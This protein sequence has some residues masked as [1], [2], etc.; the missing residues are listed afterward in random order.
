MAEGKGV[1]ESGEMETK[2][3]SK[4]TEKALENKLHK[5]IG[6]RRRLL[7]QIT[8]KKREVE[9]LMSNASNKQRVQDVMSHELSDLLVEFEDLTTQIGEL[10]T[11]DERD[12]DITTWVEPK[13]LMLEEFKEE[14]EKWMDAVGESTVGKDDKTAE[15]DGVKAADNVN[16]KVG[17]ED[18]AS[19]I[20]IG[21]IKAGKKG[22]FIGHSS[23]MTARSSVCITEE[24]K[25]AGLMERAAVLQK[26]QELELEEARIKAKLERWTLEAAIAEKRAQVKVLKEY[27]RSDDGMNS[28]VR[29]HVSGR[30]SHPLSN[31][32]GSES[33]NAFRSLQLMDAQVERPRYTDSHNR[34]TM[35][36]EMV[37]CK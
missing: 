5:L 17:P 14:V 10:L 22:S 19:Q 28:Y 7:A 33:K 36:A 26:K 9:S 18:S 11:D 27:E 20:G 25:L 30:R 2:R 37:F 8:G 23:V 35:E 6:G 29:S 31:R 13:M 4:L 21:T 15:D 1:I 16:D 34:Q 12:A 24:A 3:A 32:P